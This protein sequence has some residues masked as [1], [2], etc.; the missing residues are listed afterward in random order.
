[1]SQS[2]G[3]E[4]SFA[5]R[6]EERGPLVFCLWAKAIARP[7]EVAIGG[8]RDSYRGKKGEKGRRPSWEKSL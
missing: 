4:H 7:K 8:I 3:W 6:E 2:A 1:M 5:L